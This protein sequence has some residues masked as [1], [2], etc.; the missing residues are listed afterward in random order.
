MMHLSRMCKLEN[1]VMITRIEMLTLCPWSRSCWSYT[2]LSNKIGYIKDTWCWTNLLN[3]VGNNMLIL[4]EKYYIL[5]S[6]FGTCD[7]TYAKLWP[8]AHSERI[9][10]IIQIR[11]TFDFNIT[12]LQA[13]KLLPN[14]AHAMTVQLSCHAQNSAAI[15]SL[16]GQ[17]QNEFPSN[18]NY[19]GNIVSEMGPW[20][21]HYRVT[22]KQIST[23]FG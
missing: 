18:S 21:V 19:D 2:I 13:I 8:V 10:I 20:T 12:P 3:L 15:I 22:T 16:H 23:T 5:K 7:M 11:W 14:L 17:E 1:L 4:L 6:L 9:F